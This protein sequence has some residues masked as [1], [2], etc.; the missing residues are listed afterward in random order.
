MQGLKPAPV[1]VVEDDPD[2]RILLLELL[3]SQG[4]EV[5]LAQNGQEALAMLHSIGQPCLILL[6]LMMPVMDGWQFLAE[7]KKC[8]GASDS[9]VIVISAVADRMPMGAHPVVSKPAD[10]HRLLQLV[11]EYCPRVNA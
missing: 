1:L 9:A 6:D 11:E 8:N 3:R 10:F 4:Y 7:L 5:H 2:A